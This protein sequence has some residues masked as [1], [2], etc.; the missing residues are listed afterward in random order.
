ML[1]TVMA[2]NIGTFSKYDQRR[3]VKLICIV[4]PI[5]LYL[6][7]VIINNS[8]LLKLKNCFFSSKHSRWVW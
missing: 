7:K 6:K 3:A 8:F 5:D 1:N 2:K 4:T